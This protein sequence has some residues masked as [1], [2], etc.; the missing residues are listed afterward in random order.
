MKKLILAT[1]LILAS[2]TNAHAQEVI[3]PGVSVQLQWTDDYI[4]EPTF[5]LYLDTVLVRTFASAD[6]IKDTVA[7]TFTTKPGIVPAFTVAQLGA[8][9]WSLSASY[10]IFESGKVDIPLSIAFTTAP[11]L[12]KGFKVVRPLTLVFNEKTGELRFYRAFLKEP[13]ATTNAIPKK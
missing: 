7:H 8:H 12:P 1:A 5:K 4:I 6:L 10:T 2:F 13:V 11:A 3:P 9:T